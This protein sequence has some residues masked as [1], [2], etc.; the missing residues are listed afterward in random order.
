VQL[1]PGKSA[2]WVPEPDDRVVVL[3]ED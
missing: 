2:A 1:N 3:A